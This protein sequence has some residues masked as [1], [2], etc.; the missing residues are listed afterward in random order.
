ME[1][2]TDG[3][4]KH[5]SVTSCAPPTGDLVCNPGV[6]PDRESNRDVLVRR[7]ALSPLG[8]ASQGIKDIILNS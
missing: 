2:N 4:E 6:C 3:P 8:H 5:G 1:R 7:P